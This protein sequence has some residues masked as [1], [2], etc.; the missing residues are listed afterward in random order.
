[1]RFLIASLD[2]NGYLSASDEELVA[3]AAAEGLA[4]GADELAR[5]LGV[6][7][8]LEPRGIGAR[9]A[10]DALL[11]QLDPADPEYERLRRLLGEF[12]GELAKNKLPSVARAMNLSIDE[13]RALLA[14]L[15]ALDPHPGRQ[16]CDELSPAILPDVVVEPTPGGGFEVRVDR[17]A[18]PAV[19]V[20]PTVHE[21]A[22]DKGQT[23]Q[24]RSYLRGKIDRARWIV[25]AVEQRG[26]TLL[27]ISRSL[28]GKQR[29]FLEQGPGHLAALRMT[30]LAQEIG[31]HVSTV[32]RAV[33]GK[34]AQTPWGIYPL[35]Y[36]FQ[37]AGS[38]GSSREDVRDL[39]RRVFEREDP[40][41]P[42]S[43]DEVVAAMGAQGIELARRT[44]TKYRK[45]LG[46]P[47]S[48][49]RRRY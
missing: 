20:D 37:S 8:S 41:R 9:S 36:F 39:V 5:S 10:V 48:Y 6:L 28:F 30:D 24:V 2:A 44:V 11:L 13:V 21:L 32:S 18:W 46:I 49:R 25:E 27:R 45:E 14:R 22:R 34:Y 1:V 26:E 43:D 17:S 4:G 7:R 35:R 29:A 16:L 23:K 38:D 12:L 19:A 42:L 40:A 47:S 33:A 3:R 31:L 15:S